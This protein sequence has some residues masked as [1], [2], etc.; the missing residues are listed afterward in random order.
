MKKLIVATAL[1]LVAVGAMAQ[2]QFSFGNNIAAAG[3]NARVTD[4]ATGAPVVGPNYVAQAYVKLAGADDSSYAPIATAVPFRTSAAGAGYIVTQVLTT[5][6]ADKTAITVQMRAW[7]VT[8]GAS[9]AAAAVAGAKVGSSDP[10]NL[11]VTIAPNTPPDMV[12]LAA[13]T[14]QPIPEPSTLAL[15]ALGIV[16]FLL[17][18]RS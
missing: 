18:R 5:T 16:G 11:N 9:Y 4:K 2:G 10:V 3:I 6:F 1:G 17:R 15:G 13:F 7:D 12:G 8:Q 14:V